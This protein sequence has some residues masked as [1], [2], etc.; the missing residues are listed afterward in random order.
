MMLTLF[1]VTDIVLVFLFLKLQPAF[2]ASVFDRRQKGQ[3]LG[4][5]WLHSA[6]GR[7]FTMPA[8]SLPQKK[9]CIMRLHV[10]FT[11]CQGPEII[12]MGTIWCL[13]A[14]LVCTLE[15]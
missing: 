10:K 9:A 14:A 13:D 7:H 8:L 12:D 1:E 6:E 15:A 3:D 11:L 2:L 4:S 5:T